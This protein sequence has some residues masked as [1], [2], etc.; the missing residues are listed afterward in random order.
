M[1]ALQLAATCAAADAGASVRFAP[2]SGVNAQVQVDGAE[3]S[4]TVS[5]GTSSHTG[6][7]TI[8][9]ERRLF[10][11]V[12][13]YNFDGF[14]DVAVHHLDDGMGTYSIYRILVYVPSIGS[15]HELRPTCGD[16]FINV[17]LN[18]QR[19]TLTS[20]TFK[21]NRMIACTRRF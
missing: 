15:F 16:E 17:V 4:Y 5:R 18:P 6:S 20:S 13:D 12:A 3:V 21:N 11:T 9:T 10:V 1:L 19:K 2:A 8:D 7:L 14:Q